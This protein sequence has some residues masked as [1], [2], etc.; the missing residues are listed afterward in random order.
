[1]LPETTTLRY[2][3]P[4]EDKHGGKEL[5]FVKLRYKQPESSKSQLMSVAVMDDMHAVKGDF[6]FA[7][8]VAEFGMLLRQSKYR[9]SASYEDLLSNARRGQG[10]DSNELREGF[11]SLVRSAQTLN[12][13]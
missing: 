1:M 7:S 5:L 13:V 8:A 2:S 12:L 4:A 6:A 10:G 11:V 9:G 3:T